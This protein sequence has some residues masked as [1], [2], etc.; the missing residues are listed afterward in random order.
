MNLC[1]RVPEGRRATAPC[2]RNSRRPLGQC[3]QPGLPWAWEPGV[4]SPQYL[5]GPAP[6]CPFPEH[7]LLS[8]PELC[9]LQ[10]WSQFVGL[11]SMSCSLRPF[12]GQSTESRL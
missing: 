12:P 10:R 1:V 6:S 11:G 4:P 9:S 2:P 5:R 7:P 8:G 3:A